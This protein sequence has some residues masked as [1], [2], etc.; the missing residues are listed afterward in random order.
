[1]EK[2]TIL[3]GGCTRNQRREHLANKIVFV[4]IF[5]MVTAF[6]VKPLGAQGIFPPHQKG[7]EGH[8]AF[9]RSSPLGLTET[10][11]EELEN[12]RRAFIKEADPLWRE[13]RTLT[14]ELRYLISD[15]NVNPQTLMDRQRTISEVRGKLENLLFSFRIKARSVLTREQFGR[16][17][18]GC[19]LEMGTLY[20]AEIGIDRRLQ[21]GVRY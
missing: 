18:R 11:T 15:P 14:L 19:T 3:N 2:V 10:Q 8:G 16:L 21:R 9:W 5:F 20:E 13:L 17:P 1:M 12:I 6:G 7:R 4:F